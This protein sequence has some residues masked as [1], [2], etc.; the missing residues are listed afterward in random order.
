MVQTAHKQQTVSLTSTT[1]R[2]PTEVGIGSTNRG[3][4]VSAVSY[5]AAAE[6]LLCS[7]QKKQRSAFF[8]IYPG[9]ELEI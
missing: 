2:P 3:R 8:K 9:R 1:Y 4:H 7:A 5:T 6:E